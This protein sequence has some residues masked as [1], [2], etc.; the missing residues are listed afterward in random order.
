MFLKL[1]SVVGVLV[2]DFFG[3]CVLPV[4][5]AVVVVHRFPP[6]LP[7]LLVLVLLLGGLVL[8]P[9][10]GGGCEDRRRD[11]YCAGVAHDG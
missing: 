9:R 10:R 4:P 1:G 6:T 7:L 11:E 5:V 8:P 2:G 3:D